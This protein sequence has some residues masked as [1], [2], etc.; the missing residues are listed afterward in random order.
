[1]NKKITGI[2]SIVFV[3]LVWGSSFTVTKAIVNDISPVMLA[4][5]RFLIASAALLP[6][7]LFSKQR[8]AVKL[9]KPVDYIFISVMGLTGVTLYYTSFNLSLLYTSASSGALIQGF[10]PM[11]IALLGV[12]FLKERLTGIQLAGIVLSFIGVVM[13][14]FLADSGKDEGSLKGNLLMVSAVV[15]WS[16]Y[17]ILSKKLNHVPSLIITCLSGFAGTILLIPMVI[18]ESAYIPQS[19][20]LSFNGWL[21]VIYLGAISSALCYFLYNK[22]LETLPAAQVGNFLNLDPIIGVIIALIFLKE[23]INGWQIVGAVLVL[24]GIFL[25]TRKPK[26]AL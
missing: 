7:L 25:S 5:I 23:Q 1:M 21:A 19:V 17:T 24:T 16:I 3:M 22:A 6:V 2:L 8:K 11:S 13:V 20:T 10:M 9:L 18:F 12:I 26:T 15:C 14:G 4:F